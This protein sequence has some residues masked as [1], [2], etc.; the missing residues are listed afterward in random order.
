MVHKREEG[1][2]DCI[3]KLMKV[4]LCKHPMSLISVL[5]EA[6]LFHSPLT[7]TD[8]EQRAQER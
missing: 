8:K 6:C 5:G 2:Y 7:G 3:E 4:I 1:T